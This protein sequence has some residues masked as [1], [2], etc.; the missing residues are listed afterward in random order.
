MATNKA[1][2]TM[3]SVIQR[4]TMTS[5]ISRD[6]MATNTLLPMTK[7]MREH[8]IAISPMLANQN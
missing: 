8:M 2:I 5:S 3:T 4:T 1:D 6:I 7:T